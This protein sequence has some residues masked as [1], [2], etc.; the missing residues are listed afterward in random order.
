MTAELTIITSK[1]SVVNCSRRLG[2]RFY[3]SNRGD[4][5]IERSMAVE[6][7]V[8]GG[9]LERAELDRRKYT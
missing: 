4:T 2:K 6:V 7:E 3:A 9:E 8:D 1:A 5:D